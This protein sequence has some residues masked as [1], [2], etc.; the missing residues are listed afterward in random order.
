[1]FLGRR[2][3]KEYQM[4]SPG[5]ARMICQQDWIKKSISSGQYPC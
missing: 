3:S 2:F 4:L 5:C 1:M